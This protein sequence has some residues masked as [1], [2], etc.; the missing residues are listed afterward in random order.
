MS[1][2][3]NFEEEEESDADSGVGGANPTT[4]SDD[5]EHTEDEDDADH[6]NPSTEQDE[7]QF[8]VLW[9][10]SA[11]DP[12]FGDIDKE[13]T[14]L[15]DIPA[16]NY[17]DDDFSEEYLEVRDHSTYR[18]FLFENSDNNPDETTEDNIEENTW[19]RTRTRHIDE[20]DEEDIDDEIWSRV[21][22]ASCESLSD[23][24]E[25]GIFPDLP[26]NSYTDE[27]ID[28]I[29][30][31]VIIPTIQLDSLDIKTDS[32]QLNTEEE[33]DDDHMSR[34][35]ITNVN[36]VESDTSHDSSTQADFASLCQALSGIFLNPNDQAGN[37][38]I[39]EEDDIKDKKESAAD[40]QEQPPHHTQPPL[41][42]LAQPQPKNEN[43]EP[44]ND[45]LIPYHRTVEAPWNQESPN[46]PRITLASMFKVNSWQFQ[47]DS[48]NQNCSREACQL[49]RYCYWEREWEQRQGRGLYNYTQCVRL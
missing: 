31:E 28:D 38:Y 14:I 27:D 32:D 1:S 42:P 10:G 22:I 5:D 19:S 13:E 2:K 12:L 40:T 36:T 8:T 30:V 44:V 23:Q 20:D 7:D 11:N 4:P 17:S 34:V 18:M 37:E 25:D 46:E 3:P 26:T 35:D 43:L 41:D 21:R 33:E 47:K 24:E 9:H 6:I 29:T 48:L 39:E 16:E 49:R 15:P 45:I